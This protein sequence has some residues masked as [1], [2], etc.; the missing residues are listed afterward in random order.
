MWWGLKLS[1][2]L[3]LGLCLAV[4]IAGGHRPCRHTSLTTAWRW[5]LFA[6]SGVALMALTDLVAVHWPQRTA[7][8]G[9]CLASILLLCPP[10]AVLGSRRPG[11][12]VWTPFILI[13]LI[14]VLG[15]PIWTMLLQG[16][17]LRGLELETPTVVGFCLVLTMGVGNYFGTRFALSAL[18]YGAST[19]ILFLTCANER[20]IAE[21]DRPL[22]RTGAILGLELAMAAIWLPRRR[23]AMHPVNR[24]WD[25]FRQLYG[26]VWGLRMVERINT[27]A[28]QQN[29]TS[30]ISWTGF[31]ESSSGQLTS[32][33]PEIEDACRWLFRRFVDDEWVASRLPPTSNPSVCDAEMNASAK[34]RERLTPE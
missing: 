10:M 19:L 5:L 28:V 25:D 17:E 24:L 2:T 26:I 12:R 4:T 29:W 30:R 14:L 20:L 27:Y 31:P 16:Q 11:V 13:P 3:I 34:R 21:S 22:W 8:Y 15:W 9:W 6:I 33:E 1:L 32:D 18:L 23:K 7:D